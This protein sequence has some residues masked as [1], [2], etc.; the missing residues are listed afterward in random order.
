VYPCSF[1]IILLINADPPFNV[2]PDESPEVTPYVYTDAY[3]Q[4]IQEAPDNEA[5]HY[6]V[7]PIV[8]NGVSCPYHRFKNA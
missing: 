4:E 3:V 7:R 8:E 5:S 6:P 1:G 2:M